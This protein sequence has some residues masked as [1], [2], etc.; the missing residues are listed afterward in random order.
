[1]NFIQFINND[2]INTNIVDNG[3]RGNVRSD[4]EKRARSKLR[5]FITR[6]TPQYCTMIAQNI[7]QYEIKKGTRH[8]KTQGQSELI[9]RHL[10]YL[11]SAV[12]G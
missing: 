5:Y 3:I 12:I 8:Q 6:T 4:S 11:K 7:A 2:P 9:I 1:M 10:G